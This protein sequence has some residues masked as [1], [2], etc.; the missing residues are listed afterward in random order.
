MVRDGPHRGEIVKFCVEEETVRLPEV[1]LFS[2]R[3]SGRIARA[4]ALSGEAMRREK[5]GRHTEKRK[6]PLPSSTFRHARGHF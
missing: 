3:L 6:E 2:F 1:S 5:R 4:R